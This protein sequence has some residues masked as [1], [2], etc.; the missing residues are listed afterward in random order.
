MT[1]DQMAR[2]GALVQGL[3]FARSLANSA[4]VFAFPASHGDWVRPGLA[5]YGVSPFAGTHG[6]ALGLVPAMR[7]MSTVI[8]L[9][10]VPAGQTVGYGGAWRARRDSRLAIVAAGY[11]DGLPW[12]LPSG[13]PVLV[14]GQMLPLAGRVSMDMIA[15]DVTDTPVRIGDEVLLWGAELPVESQAR[16]AGTIPWELLCAVSQRVPLLVT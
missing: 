16:A 10:N 14:S 1:A 13:T 6:A 15:V 8:S 3:P 11:G 12:S 5:L 4:A 9:R 2:F 7:L